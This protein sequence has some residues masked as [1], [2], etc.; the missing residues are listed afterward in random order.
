MILFIVCFKWYSLKWDKILNWH[1]ECLLRQCINPFI[2][3]IRSICWRPFWIQ[4]INLMASWDRSQ[5]IQFTVNKD[6]HTRINLTAHSHKLWVFSLLAYLN[7]VFSSLNKDKWLAG[8]H[9]IRNRYKTQ[10]K[11][12]SSFHYATF[13]LNKKVTPKTPRFA[14]ISNSAKTWSLP[15]RILPYKGRDTQVNN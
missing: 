5:T 7:S 12:S 4:G 8:T 15:S 6:L 14:G 13:P 3:N 9:I 1:K 11:I 10:D 2:D